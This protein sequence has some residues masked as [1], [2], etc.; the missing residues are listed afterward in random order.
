MTDRDRLAVAASALLGGRWQVALA[1]L[2][3]VKDRSVRRW[4]SG[5]RAVP[6][7]ALVRLREELL[8]HSGELKKLAKALPKQPP[9]RRGEE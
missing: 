2:L 1:K 9:P 7:W 3:G 5:E 6:G 4:H 8:K